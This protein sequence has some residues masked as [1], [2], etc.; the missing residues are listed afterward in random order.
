MCIIQSIMYLFYIFSAFIL[1]YFLISLPVRQRLPNA[2]ASQQNFLP[3][4]FD[5]KFCSKALFTIIL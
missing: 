2:K 3:K 4:N 5:F 1:S